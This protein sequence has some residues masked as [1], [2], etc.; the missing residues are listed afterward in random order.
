MG[1]FDPEVYFLLACVYENDQQFND[2]YEHFQESFEL[3][4]SYILSLEGK[5]RVCKELIAQGEQ[6]RTLE[7]IRDEGLLDKLSKPEDK[8]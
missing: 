3:D 4:T 1:F 5:V 2:A 7:M 6:W 8:E